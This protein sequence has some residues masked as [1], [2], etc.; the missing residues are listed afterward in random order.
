MLITL[1]LFILV[2]SVERITVL[3][4]QLLEL[5][6]KL[7]NL[8][9]KSALYRVCIEEA[10]DFLFTEQE[11]V[12][13]QR[14]HINIALDDSLEKLSKIGALRFLPFDFRSGI[15]VNTGSFGV[16][17]LVLVTRGKVSASGQQLINLVLDL[18]DLRSGVDHITIIGTG[19][20][21]DL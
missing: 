20:R 17:R 18:D 10:L 6:V 3:C 5:Q 21:V 14:L 15:G 16:D 19:T 1:S 12:F 8:L 4:L 9:A 13:D 2:E 7:L 11:F